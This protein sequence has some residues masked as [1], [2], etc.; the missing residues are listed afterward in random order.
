M[1]GRRKGGRNLGT[2]KDRSEGMNIRKKVVGEMVGDPSFLKK[3]NSYKHV[4]I[5]TGWK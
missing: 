4:S 2:G 1:K 5:K 3:S